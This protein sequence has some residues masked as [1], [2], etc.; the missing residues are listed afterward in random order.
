M[1]WEILALITQ[2]RYFNKYAKM[3][4]RVYWVDDSSEKVKMHLAV[5][6]LNVFL[7]IVTLDNWNIHNFRSAT[8]NAVGR[9]SYGFYIDE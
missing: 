9:S 7:L 5:N 3:P 8:V 4:A 6:E 1:A 2:L